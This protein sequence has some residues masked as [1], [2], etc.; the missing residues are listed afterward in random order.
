MALIDDRGRLFGRI[1]LIDIAAALVILLLIPLGYGAYQLFRTPPP[2]I[3]A[4]E[5]GTLTQGSDLSVTLEARHL[6]PFLRAVVGPFEAELLVQTPTRAEIKLP[7]LLELGSHDLVLY[8]VAREVARHPAAVTIEAP[9]GAPPPPPLPPPTLLQMRV[10]GAFTGLDR[11]RTA[12]PARSETFGMEGEIGAGEILAVAPAEPEAM[13]LGGFPPLARSDAGTVRVVVLVRVWCELIGADCRVGGTNVVPGESL[14]LVR[15]DN[16][17]ARFEVM[18]LYLPSTELQT[19]VTVMGAFVGLDDAQADRISG[20]DESS[21]V[22]SDSWGRV[23]SLGRLEPENIQLTGG[24]RAGTTGKNR[25]P[26]L[27]SIH[28]AI[29]GQQCWLGSQVVGPT[30]RLAIPTSEGIVW[31]EIAELYPAAMTAFPPPPPVLEIRVLGAF[32]GLD[33]ADPAMPERSETFGT[34]GE[35]GSGEIIAVAPVEREALDLAGVPS[36]ARGDLDTV[37]VVALV[38]VRCA[39]VENDCRVG[40]ALVVPGTAL[41]IVRGN[42]SFSFRVMELYRSPIELQAEVTVM[43]AFVGLDDARADR[44]SGLDESSDVASDSWGRVLSLGRPE[45]ENLELTG[46]VRAGITGKRRVRGLVAI[47][48]AIVGHEC[49]RGNK[50]VGPGERLA[51][52]TSEGIVWFEVTENYPAANDRLVELKVSGAFVGLEREQAE[53]LGTMT[54]SDQPNHPWGKILGVAPPVPETVELREDSGVFS[55]GTT[56]KFK[57]EAL[58]AVRCL[59]SGTECRLGSTLI[60]SEA[61]LSIPTPEGLLLFDATEIQ[62]AETTL[63]DITVRSATD[64]TILSLVRNGLSMEQAEAQQG[65][66]TPSGVTLLAVGEIEEETTLRTSYGAYSWE[67][68]GVVVSVILRVPAHQTVSGWQYGLGTET[69]VPLRAGEAFSYTQPSYVLAGVITSVE[70]ASVDQGNTSR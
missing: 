69:F 1:N 9:L 53:K 6:Q 4:I 45:P 29:V 44:I 65:R 56:G 63:V 48:C 51:L 2:E 46:G 24:V 49:W 34:E 3:L 35:I 15:G 30:A 58:V 55:A 52:P 50:V 16:E 11:E 70:V 33:P 19:E 54:L 59:V 47:R 8:D 37:R 27:V 62:P 13:E 42:E 36:V 14:G 40:G 28:C 18:E 31:F 7:E 5:P 60:G 23:L 25:I 43:G 66:Q 61:M 21:E 12:M 68:P 32:T 64:R 22:S 26:A 10:L 20:L 17:R 57:V 41:D 38:R 67:Q 39:L